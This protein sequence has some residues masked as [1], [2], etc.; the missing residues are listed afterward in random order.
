[1]LVAPREDFPELAH[2]E[3]FSVDG[4]VDKLFQLGDQI[5]N[6]RCRAYF[7]RDLDYVSVTQEI[8]A[9][10]DLYAELDLPAIVGEGDEIL[11]QARYHALGEARLQ[12][13]TPTE[14]VE[15]TVDG[16]GMVEFPLTAPGQVSAHIA[17]GT[18][19]DTSQRTVDAPG[20]ETVTASRLALLRRGET[21]SGV[22]VVVFP[23]MGPL[24]QETIEALIHYPFG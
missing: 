10:L 4:S 3:L 19:S 14:Q 18:G 8:R 20:Q 23:S 13:T 9:A 11:P 17:S 2:I 15:Y 7:F 5:G 12:V 1:M 24:L 21:V 16:D 6:W 22:R